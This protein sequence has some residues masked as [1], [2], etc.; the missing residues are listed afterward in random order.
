M[1]IYPAESISE[2]VFANVYSSTMYLTVINQPSKLPLSQV[3][4]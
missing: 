1:R 3:T 4:A 2:K